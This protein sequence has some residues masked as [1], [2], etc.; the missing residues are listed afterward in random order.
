MLFFCFYSSKSYLIS[1]RAL[2][3]KNAGNALYK[4]KKFEE[5]L[6]EY[7]KAIEIE[8]TEATFYGNVAAVFL[9]QKKY[10]ECIEQSKKACEVAKENMGYEAVGKFVGKAYTRIGNA[11]Y[12]QSMFAEAV[13]AYEKSLMECYNRDTEKRLKLIKKKKT[14]ADKKAYLNPEEGLK[15]KTRGN[16]FFKQG[17]WP[18]AV[19]EYS[20]A[21]KRDP[22]NAVYYG[23]R[24]AAYTKLM[25]FGLGMEDCEKALILDPSYVKAWGRKGDIEFM[26]RKYHRA[27]ESYDAGLMLDANNANCTEGKVRTANAIN[28]CLTS[29]KSDPERAARA[30]EDPEIQALMNDAEVTSVLNAMKAGD[31]A[32]TQ[33]AMR[34][35]SIAAKISTLVAAGVLGMG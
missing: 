15:A 27:L 20:E 34:V 14:E 13:S 23:N 21:I 30:M 10:D 35:P 4:E 33:K 17:N 9:E 1:E 2:V 26:L 3:H 24:A 8:P 18:K 5:A 6:V 12:K 25:E 29:G 31:N 11:Y 32:E 28:A 22:E 16:E 19:H 7:N